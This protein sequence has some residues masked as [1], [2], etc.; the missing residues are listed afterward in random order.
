MAQYW[1][2]CQRLLIPIAVPPAK[3]SSRLVALGSGPAVV[4]M[5]DSSALFRMSGFIPD[6]ASMK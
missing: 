6:R 3:C 4:A 1:P 2:R 5:A